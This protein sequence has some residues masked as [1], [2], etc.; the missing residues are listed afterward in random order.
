MLIVS[1]KFHCS[2]LGMMITGS[3]IKLPGPK[4]R[5]YHLL[6]ALPSNGDNNSIFLTELGLMRIMHLHIMGIA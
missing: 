3:E 4:L 6:A 1:H 5:F 2:I